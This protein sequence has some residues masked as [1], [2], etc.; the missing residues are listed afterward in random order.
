MTPLEL[1]S[2]LEPLVDDYLLEQLTGTRLKLH[3]PQRQPLARQPLPE[4]AY[5]TVLQDG[6]RYHAYFRALRPDIPVTLKRDGHPAEMTC[7][8]ESDDGIDWRLTPLGLHDLGGSRDNAAI[9]T[10]A[11]FCHNL[12]P[13]LDARPGVPPEERYKALAGVHQHAYANLHRDYPTDPRYLEGETRGGLWAFCSPDGLRWRKWSTGPVIT[14]ADFGFDSQNVSFWSVT[15][16]CYVAYVRSWQTRHGRLRTISRCTSADYLHWSAPVALEPNVP[17]EHL[18]TSQ[19]HPY[20]RAPHLYLATPTRFAGD[21]RGASTDI[22]FMTAR[23]NAPYARPFK[24]AWLRPGLD[25]A[26]W[27][28]RANYLGLNILPTSPEEL[29]LYHARSGYRYTLR[30]DGFISVWAGQSGGE[31]Q[32]KPLCFTGSRLW[33][34]LSTAAGGAV[35]V[36]L[37]RP[38]GTPVPG[39]ALADCPPFWGDAI[40]LPVT[41]RGGQDVSALAGQPIR[42]RLVM[43]EAD[44]YALR[45][46]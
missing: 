1:G 26:R 34:N 32:T 29:T 4:S 23:G 43:Q 13:M 33:L 21:T 5:L 2:R 11:P 19:T 9:L 14:L 20:C 45:F 16:G 30:T 44:L 31:L 12:S 42:L 35:Q 10:E 15:E 17:G 25:A 18:Y 37:Q 27:G 41:W 8:A 6:G 7:H 36:E 28:N 40:A 24:E 46:A 39:Y 38:D 22:L 3:E